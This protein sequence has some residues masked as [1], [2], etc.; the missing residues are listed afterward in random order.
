M[1]TLTEFDALLA[2]VL[3]PGSLYAVGGRVRDELRA[4]ARNG[5]AT[6]KDGDYVVIG[7]SYDELEARL[8]P[9]GAV[10]RVGAIFSVIKLTRDGVTVDVALPRRESSTGSGHRDFVIE[11][12]PEVPLVDDLARRDFR[13]NM[14]ARAI[15]SGELVDPYAG[16][17]DIR[18]QQIDILREEAFIEDPLRMLR[19]CQFA[20][21]FGYALTS[22]T[23]NAMRTAAQ[24]VNTVSPQRIGEELSKMLKAAHKPS[25][26]IELMRITGLLDKIWPEIAEGYGVEQN[27]WHLYDVYRHNLETLDATP[28]NNLVLR[29]SALLHDIGKPRVKDGPHFYKHELVGADMAREM[30]LRT[31]FPND[32][33]DQV[34]L[35]VRNHMYC[36]DAAVTDAAV[37]R[38]IRR[39]GVDALDHIF[40]LR[41]ADIIG[42]GLPKRDSSD[43][44]F[45]ARVACEL[46]QKPALSTRDLALN[47]RDVIALYLEHG[48]ALPMRGD[49]R[50]GEVLAALFEHVT[51][52]PSL[53]EPVALRELAH[54]FLKAKLN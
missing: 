21:R 41:A 17:A 10:D 38:F 30:L 50:V 13:M 12:G 35:L 3:P 19:A 8:A 16:A 20:A 43:Q 29:L 14:I 54:R 39:I 11:S 40:S 33:I 44:E 45:Q 23:L 25:T 49:R 2:A 24:F 5:Q 32:V 1:P 22:R 15:P 48:I 28:E 51:D 27:E 36:A 6:I 47:G 7:L 37:R 42:S 4:E 9:L 53:N 46:L 31:A 26:G 18:A 34:C 52:D